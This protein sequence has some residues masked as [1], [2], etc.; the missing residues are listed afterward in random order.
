[1]SC[2]HTE[3]SSCHVWTIAFLWTQVLSYICLLRLTLYLFIVVDVGMIKCL[4]YYSILLQ[5]RNRVCW[6]ERRYIQESTNSHSRHLGMFWRSRLRWIPWYRYYHNVRRLPDPSSAAFLWCSRIFW[7]T[8][9]IL[10]KRSPN[11]FWYV[12]IFTNE[13][14][15]CVL[16][17]D[18]HIHLL[19]LFR[20]TLIT[21]MFDNR[22]GILVIWYNNTDIGILSSSRNLDMLSLEKM[23]INLSFQGT[24]T[25]SRSEDAASG[26]QNL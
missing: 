17:L 14:V 8:K 22:Q 7:K 25:R 4:P 16:A 9:R 18:L 11:E 20:N 12:F 19:E 1:M 23:Q 10:E 6:K 3:N 26:R 15:C 2:R 5:G 24:G 13:N 21:C